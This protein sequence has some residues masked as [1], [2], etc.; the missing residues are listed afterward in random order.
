M[1]DQDTPA[2][3]SV[4]DRIRELLPTMSPSERRVARALLTG[5]PTAG[6]ESSRRL[7]EAA[8]VSGPTVSRFVQRLGFDG[9]PAFQAATHADVAA[10][11]MSPIE[12]YRAH[13][14]GSGGRDD[15]SQRAEALSRAMSVSLNE[16]APETLRAVTAM[17]VDDKRT[18]FTAGGWFSHVLAEHLGA[19]LRHFRPR[20]RNASV[21]SIDRAFTVADITRRDVL[22]VFD[23][24]RYERG[25]LE[26][27]EAVHDRGARIILFTD[28]WLSPVADLAEVTITARVTGPAPF[29]TLVPTLAL[30]ET[31]VAS[32]ANAL[33]DAGHRHF[34]R[35]SD[36]ADHWVRPWPPPPS[37]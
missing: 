15:V 17:L 14:A 12:V 7:A 32:V 33:G 19:L 36:V 13:V 22:V 5:A 29:E 8:G 4:A 24:R 35:F 6:L 23:F 18:V 2:G 28:P 25:T 16:L 10:R 9:Y 11:V 26:L 37:G 31:I 30:V 34:V 27:A 20:V 1:T 3:V 21:S